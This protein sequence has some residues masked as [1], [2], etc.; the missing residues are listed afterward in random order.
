MPVILAPK[1]YE[2]WLGVKPAIQEPD[3]LQ[4]LLR[5]HPP[6]AMMAYPVSARVNNPLNDTPE[7]IAPLGGGPDDE[8]WGG[9]RATGAGE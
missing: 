7:C 3:R 1:D 5:P 8:P 4:P 2:L 6:E 9:S